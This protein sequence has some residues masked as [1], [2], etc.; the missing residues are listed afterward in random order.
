MPSVDE[1][2]ARACEL[3]RDFHVVDLAW[4]RSTPWRE[5][6]AMS[7]D[8]APMRPE[9]RRLTAVTV[10]H[11]PDSAVAGLLLV[12]WLA[13]RL[14]WT[15]GAMIR[16]HDLLYG[17]ATGPRQDVALTLEPEEALS[18]PGLAGITIEMASG[19]SLALDRGPGGL[20]AERRTRDGRKWR[21]TIMGASRGESGILGDGIRAA[22]L[23]DR[24]YG[25]A[26][27]C[28]TRMLR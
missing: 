21:W 7:F 18:A 8:P 10:R 16:R 14:G 1:A 23:R 6:I 15:P 3:T 11:H 17:R 4:L 22:L 20:H 13:A 19:T 12:G 9:L 5:R 2:L 24:T 28:A 25:P 26:L 27:A